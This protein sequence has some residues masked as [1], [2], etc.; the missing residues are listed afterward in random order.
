M[1]RWSWLLG[2]LVIGVLGV[3]WWTSRNAIRM[4]PLDAQRFAQMR[5]TEQVEWLIEQILARSKRTDTLTM[6]LERVPFLQRAQDTHPL[7]PINVGVIATACVEYDL[8]HW[9]HRCKGY[10]ESEP[11]R[12]RLQV[13]QAILQARRGNWRAAEQVVQRIP[14][15]S[16]RALALAHLGRLQME[17]GQSDAARHTFEQAYSLLTQPID[18]NRVFEVFDALNLLVRFSHF[19]EHPEKVARILQSFPANFHDVLVCRIAEVYRQRGDLEQLNR[20][21]AAAQPTSRGIVRAKLAHALIEQGRVDEGL[22][23]LAQLSSCPAELIAPIARSLHQQGRKNDAQILVDILYKIV[24]YYPRKFTPSMTQISGVLLKTP[25][26]WISIS[27]GLGLAEQRLLLTQLVCLYI[28]WGQEARAEQ[29]IEASPHLKMEEFA[30]L[31][32]YNI[33]LAYH[34]VGKQAQAYQHLEK[35]LAKIRK[36]PDLQRGWGAVILRGGIVDTY[37]R[38]G[39]CVRALEMAET[40]LSP[41]EQ[42]E[43]LVALLRERA[44]NRNPLWR[45]LSETGL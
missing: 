34:Q 24:E 30:L 20:L 1:R 43:G 8:P 16:A 7:T 5:E 14:T 12:E 41:A 38:L 36:N 27:P 3:V 39:D 17:T 42:R 6:I 13:Y 33:A 4:E 29:L 45:Q 21:I 37:A 15:P 32:H 18:V 31:I 2:L 22:K 44:Y 9:L 25:Y 10:V 11:D 35:A 23:M 26:G 19:G 40:M 28:E